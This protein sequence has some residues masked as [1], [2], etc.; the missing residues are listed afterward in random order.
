LQLDASVAGS[1]AGGKRVAER[2][3]VLQHVSAHCNV[4][5]QW[6]L[7]P[8]KKEQDK[9]VVVAC[10]KMAQG[11]TEWCQMFRCVI[12]CSDWFKWVKARCNV[13]CV[14]T[15]RTVPLR[16]AVC[17]N[18]LKWVASKFR[19]KNTYDNR[20]VSRNKCV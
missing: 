16:A 8:K 9:K 15:G 14:M 4:L 2:H 6:M 10:S 13:L 20:Y 3:S 11:V 18:A 17:C 7:Q 5:R 1:R 19:N 12:V